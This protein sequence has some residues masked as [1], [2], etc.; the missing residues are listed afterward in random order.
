MSDNIKDILRILLL[1]IAGIMGIIFLTSPSVDKPVDTGD[2]F[3]EAPAVGG[4]VWNS[5]M[6]NKASTTSRI[7]VTSN[8]FVLG[9]ST[10]EFQLAYTALCNDS[11]NII[12]IGLD[13]DKPMTPLTGIRLN[14]NGG[15]LEL[16]ENNLYIG[17]IRATSTNEIPSA[18]LVN[19][20]TL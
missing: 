16:N 14:P 8:T 15:C 13:G 18:L 5:T 6:F 12:Y 9:S 7:M 20:Y 19:S 11:P 17:S 4:S 3:V 1:F 10:P 2:K